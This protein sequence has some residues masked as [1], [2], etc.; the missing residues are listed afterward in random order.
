MAKLVISSAS[1]GINSGAVERL[2]VIF[3]DGLRFREKKIDGFCFDR[4]V[5]TRGLLL[6]FKLVPLRSLTLHLSI[7]SSVTR[8]PLKSIRRQEF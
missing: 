8:Y 6:L 1:P 5:D 4:I 7:V 3:S 2:F